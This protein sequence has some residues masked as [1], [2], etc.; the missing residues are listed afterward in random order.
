MSRTA[1]RARAQ[2]SALPAAGR[3][4]WLHRGLVGAYTLL[5]VVL[6]TPALMAPQTLA[7]AADDGLRWAVVDAGARADLEVRYLTD[8]S[9]D[10]S[11]KL[12]GIADATVRA[13]PDATAGSAGSPAALADLGTNRVLAG[14]TTY[15]VRRAAVHGADVTW[16][17]GQAPRAGAS[18][19]EMPGTGPAVLEVGLSEGTARAMGVTVGDQLP[20]PGHHTTL[21]VAGVFEPADPEG[22]PWRQAPSLLHPEAAF[23]PVRHVTALV[24]P[25]PAQKQG[26]DEVSETPVTVWVPVDPS[27]IRVADIGGLQQDLAFLA[28]HE[29]LLGTAATFDQPTFTTG[30]ADLLS[31]YQARYQVVRSQ[32]TTLLL[33]LAVAAA[34]VLRLAAG[35]LVARRDQALAL[36]RARG[37]SMASVAVRAAAESVPV[38]VVAAAVAALVAGRLG[39]L[40]AG[41]GLVPAG[42]VLAATVLAPVWLSARQA[43]SSWSARRVPTDRA[44]RA[45]QDRARRSW[46]VALQVG[47]LVVAA[48]A[49]A[50]AGARGFDARGDL[51]VS[52]APVLLAAACTILV[53]LA[54]PSGLR[55]VAR[56]AARG[57]SVVPLVAATR[58][59]AASAGAG[60]GRRGDGG[61]GAASVLSLVVVAALAVFAAAQ[62]ATV[63]VARDR[64]VDARV[65]AAVRVDDPEPGYA[66]W[67]ASRFPGLAVHAGS[68]LPQRDFA[69]GSGLEVTVLAV[70]DPAAFPG[71]AALAGAGPVALGDPV[72]A[73]LDARLV[74]AAQ[75][76]TPDVLAVRTMMTVAMIGTVD[77]ARTGPS[78]GTGDLPDEPVVVVDR[79]AMAIALGLEARDL[80]RDDIVWLD[81]PDAE[82]AAALPA[83]KDAVVTSPAQLGELLR[84]DPLVGGVTTLLRASAGVLAGLCAVVVALA[85][86]G[87]DRD[88]LRVLAV[89]RTLGV[90]RRSGR[91]L[92]IAELA[93]VLGAAVVAGC[94][95][96]ALLT[97]VLIPAQGLEALAYGGAV[98]PV[99]AWWPFLAVPGAAACALL[100]GAWLEERGRRHV[101]VGEVL[102]T[103]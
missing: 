40:P 31:S 88:R 5:A 26:D 23:G 35:M 93:P 61:P 51:L 69:T 89:L 3:R 1:A 77:L 7:R 103:W 81:G 29:S 92:A 48:A 43:S 64:A 37:A 78:L 86:L 74:H 22:L 54:V 63:V 73:L 85:V 50:A 84:A 91:T 72:P 13:L 16:V 62:A 102:R 12:A 97:V 9:Q 15:V 33:G 8:P 80:P 101:R 98:E 59:A 53:L 95:A 71:F 49:V 14:A 32:V 18:E 67:V 60:R 75:S 56:T 65:G 39:E 100:V 42:V 36:E 94:L 79:Q 96:G 17:D 70:D 99:L 4:T 68:V 76:L 24:A 6:V 82:R 57:R 30:L 21:T 45:V 10:V 2:V 20:D 46:G 28:A 47:V 44:D 19:P 25:P 66:Q 87:G 55:L 38:G 58:T 27:A 11:T 52:A 83:G 34:L 41:T 90:P